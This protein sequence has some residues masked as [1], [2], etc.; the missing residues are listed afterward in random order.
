MKRL[1][2]FLLP[3]LLL[4]GCSFSGKPPEFSQTEFLMDTV[5]TIRSDSE[6]AILSGFET[7]REIQKATDFYDDGSTVAV[8]NRTPAGV[9][10]T[11]DFH[12]ETIVDAA[13]S[14]SSASN[15]AFDITIAPA[16]KLW[17]FTEG[18]T[19]PESSAIAQALPCI[20]WEKLILDNQN[21]T[22]TKTAEGVAIDLGGC[23]KGYAADMAKNAMM[24]AGATWGILDLGGNVVV[25]GKNPARNE[26][27]WE[28]GIQDPSS[29]TGA[30]T[31]TVTLEESGAVVTSGTYQR[32]FSYS[33]R[34]FHHILDPK[35]GYPAKT[36][37]KSA[38][39]TGTS[40]LYADCLSTACLILG[41]EKGTT[42]ADR[43]GASVFFSD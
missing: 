43:F 27:G 40:A 36:E 13:L 5:C 38:T 33:G 17:D 32:K 15:G 29:A 22:L 39:V 6:T 19:P 42:L 24:E 12:T 31:R 9:P 3:C 37:T 41:R 14:V 16:S 21:H 1:L 11:L 34:L 7:I 8:F 26:G 28:I 25:F 23:A 10:V 2:A 18:A 35:T 30:Y 4:S 20:G